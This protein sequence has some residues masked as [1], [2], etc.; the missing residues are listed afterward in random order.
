MHRYGGPAADIEPPR[1]LAM[2][3]SFIDNRQP[4]RCI[5]LH[6]NISRSRTIDRKR[7]PVWLSTVV[8]V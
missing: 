5:E 3:Q 1:R 7:D 2:A 8:S 4:N 6:A